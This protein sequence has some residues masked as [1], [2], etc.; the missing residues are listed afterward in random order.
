VTI[1]QTVGQMALAV[2]VHLIAE[3][4]RGFRNFFSSMLV[5]RAGIAEQKISPHPFWM[6]PACG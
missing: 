3:T 4:P 1:A 2:D 6:E 5:H